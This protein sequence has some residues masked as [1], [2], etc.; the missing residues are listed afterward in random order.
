MDGGGVASPGLRGA[1]RQR[2]GPLPSPPEFASPRPGRCGALASR[3]VPARPC[4]SA[5][6]G[7]G[8]GRGPSGE[9]CARVEV[10]GLA[11]P[12]GPGWGAPLNRAGPRTSPAC[13]PRATPRARS[14]ENFSPRGPLERVKLRGSSPQT[15]EDHCWTPFSG[16]QVL[17]VSVH[18]PQTLRKTQKRCPGYL[19]S[20]P[21]N[22]LTPVL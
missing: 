3:A 8:A 17:W 10:R 20:F 7:R 12:G 18:S 22:F 19:N 9:L 6:R 1:G 5:A 16:K 4:Q 21:S 15:R 11:R 2:L 13:P 14:P